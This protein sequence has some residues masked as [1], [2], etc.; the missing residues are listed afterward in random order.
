MI[1]KLCLL[2]KLSVKQRKMRNI[3]IALLLIC[4]EDPGKG[5]RIPLDS[6]LVL[7]AF[8]YISDYQFYISSLKVNSTLKFI[9]FLKKQIN[10]LT[11]IF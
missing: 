8:S 5:A 6:L 1:K 3:F 7:F 9:G 2:A 11:N 10:N 4:M